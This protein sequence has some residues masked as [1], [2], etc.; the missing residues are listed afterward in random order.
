MEYINISV[1]SP[2]ILHCRDQSIKIVV[3]VPFRHPLENQPVVP[4]SPV[5]VC[6]GC[7]HSY[8]GLVN[9]LGRLRVL[10]LSNE[11]YRLD[12]SVRFLLL[13][14]EIIRELDCILHPG[15]ASHRV[16]DF[17]STECS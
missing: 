11:M 12:I 17:I 13:V 16:C 4:S 14:H 9:L 10:Q 7:L 15:I 5:L 8:P 2:I 6:L 3:V 1:S